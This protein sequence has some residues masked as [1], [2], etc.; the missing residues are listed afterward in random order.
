MNDLNYLV[1]ISIRKFLI[2]TRSDDV[3]RTVKGEAMFYLIIGIVILAA[4]FIWMEIVERQI[5]EWEKEK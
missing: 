3:V 1:E 5:Q 4:P 2:T